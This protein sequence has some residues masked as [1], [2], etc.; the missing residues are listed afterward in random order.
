MVNSWLGIDKSLN[1]GVK[2][3]LLQILEDIFIL[4]S[5]CCEKLRDS[6]VIIWLLV[7]GNIEKNW[8]DFSVRFSKTGLSMFRQVWRTHITK[9]WHMAPNKSTYINNFTK[10]IDLLYTNTPIGVGG[11]FFN[12]TLF[13]SK[14]GLGHQDF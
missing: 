8:I 6:R 9:I 2:Y 5:Y 7:K 11:W 13:R 3:Y 1:F 10:K 4:E 12:F 14:I